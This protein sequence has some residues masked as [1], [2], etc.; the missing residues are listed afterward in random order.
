MISRFFIERPLFACVLSGFILTAGLVALRVLPVS[1]YPDILPPMI[2]VAARYPGA[3]PE[4]ISETVAAPLEQQINGTEDMM[5]VRSVASANGACSVVATFA[6]GTNPDLAV[7]NVQN[8]VQ[9]ALPRLPEAVRREGVV[10][11]KMI[12]TAVMYI[13]VDSPD[14][15]YDP[16]FVSNYTMINIVEQLRR[17]PGTASVDLIGAREF[18]IRVWLYPDKLA[19]MNLTAKDVA[20][21][22]N[23]QNAQFATGRI[24]D[25]PTS[26]FVDL[27]MSITAQ[28]RLSTPS[29]FEKIIIKSDSNGAVV[30]LK[31]VARVE[32]GSQDFSVSP[33]QNGKFVA[34]IGIFPQPGAN[35]LDI[36]NRVNATMNELDDKFPPGLRW[37]IPWDT[38][39][40]VR[41]AIK[42]V[43]K[44]LLEAMLLVFLVVFLFLQNWK[45]TLIPCLAVPVSLIGAMAGIYVLGANIN[46]A[47][48]FAMVLSI[49]IVVDDAIV[50]LENVERHM[51]NDKLDAK[52]ATQLAMA[53]VT[54]P[55]IAIVLVLTAVFLP[56]AFLG[57]LAG[58]MYRQ[59]AI[60]I[61]TSV[62][63]SGFVAL[64]LTPALCALLLKPAPHVPSRMGE[65]YRA[66]FERMT[67]RYAT[68]IGFLVR[69]GLLS[70]GLM[71][72]ILGATYGLSRN[73]PASLVPD[74]DQGYV[75]ALPFLPPGASLKRTDTVMHQIQDHFKGHPA[76]LETFGFSGYDPYCFMPRT[77]SAYGWMCLKHWD[78]RKD[79]TLQ[80][81][82]IVN[83]INAL[84]GQIKDAQVYG[85]G[86]PPIE[87][88]SSVGGFE[89]FVQSRAGTDYNALETAVAKLVAAAAVRPELMGVLT[90]FT[91]QVPQ[92]RLNVNRE[93]AKLLDVDIDEV[94]DI[95]QSTFGAYYVNDFNMLGRVYQVQMQSDAQYRTHLHDLGHVYMR[96]RSGS[97]IP[98][99]AIATVKIITGPDII[100][101][102]NVFPAARI[103][104]MPAP[105]YSSGQALE[106]MEQLAREHL[107]EGY[108]LAWAGQS[109]LEKETKKDT[110]WIYILAMLMVFMILAAQYESLTLPLAVI[111][112]VP[113]AAFGAFVAVWMRGLYNDVYLQ[114]GLVTLVGLA[115]KNAILIVEFAAKMVHEGVDLS[116]AAMKAARL[117]FRPILMTSM[118]FILGVLPLAI[119]SG[120]GAN[121][122]H[123]IGTG[124]I[125]GMLAATFIATFFVPV[126]FVWVVKLGKNVVLFFSRRTHHSD[127]AG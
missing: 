104:G 18:A 9:A 71:L 107:P 119:S 121:S 3:T 124:V 111:L 20:R 48:L 58:E 64:T 4:V 2:E 12:W 54:K 53:E 35:V 94:F 38:N 126:F 83:E 109:F 80:A 82:A 103:M 65:K 43:L 1:L 69:H 14:G 92:V 7:I 24:G 28:G 100:E 56:V 25:E 77:S 79:K 122:R 37:Q 6:I 11:R 29:E 73:I 78:E 39:W 5:F 105:G 84:A 99:T 118:A 108:T 26:E 46:L 89:A 10:V 49:G 117:R 115:A 125:G 123:S 40:F 75:I 62:I 85:I 19:Q 57:G 52:K 47:S 63:I 59:F 102:F 95:L 76:V 70:L 31:D 101:R 113:F 127:N 110:A 120:A 88:L 68:G 13:I 16:S 86:P 81:P 27:T 67:L 90:S 30:H 55:V 112:S 21:A 36:G 114:I 66:W 22:I 72:S 106:I 87:G 44:T 51:R 61:S 45:A 34:C 42:E 8:R 32:L 74:E 91:A 33:T 116:E 15:R 93:Q 60:T 23:E 17:L 98:L 41:V 97:P 50:V 96:S